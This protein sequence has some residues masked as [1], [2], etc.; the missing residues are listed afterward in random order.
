MTTLSITVPDELRAAAEQAVASGRFATVS[1]YVATLIRQDQERNRDE[2]VE[3]RLLQRLNAGPAEQL[4]DACFDRVRQRL[5]AEVAQ[6]R[7]T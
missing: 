2:D 5:D 3:A 6:R 4:T 1:E 7:G